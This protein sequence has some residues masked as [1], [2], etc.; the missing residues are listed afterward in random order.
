LYIV[1]LSPGTAILLWSLAIYLTQCGLELFWIGELAG[2][3]GEAWRRRRRRRRRHIS[4]VTSRDDE[5]Q[6]YLF[7]NNTVQRPK[8]R[9]TLANW[10][11]SRFA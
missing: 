10:G 2:G 11:E 6:A 9:K 5:S 7:P 4:L 1:I 8:F 3:W